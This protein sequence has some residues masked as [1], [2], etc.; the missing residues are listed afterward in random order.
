[1]K[2]TVVST[3]IN[4]LENLYGEEVINEAKRESNWDENMIITPLMNIE[5]EK[6]FDLINTMA[7]KV[8]KKE[9]ELWREIGKQNIYS[10]SEWFPSYFEGRQLKNFL[11]L[12]DT[13]HKQL[14]KMIP[15]ANPPR[16]IPREIDNR[17]IELT[18]SSQ[19]GMFDYFLGLLEGSSEFFEEDIDFKEKS[20]NTT[21]EKKSLKVV[22]TFSEKFKSTHNYRLS[23]FLSFGIFNKIK[24]KLAIAFIV[25]NL[26]TLYGFSF[27]HPLGLTLINGGFALLLTHFLTKPFNI[28]NKDLDRI[29]DLDLSDSINLKSNDEF[30]EVTRHMREIK[31]SIRKDILF[32][33]GGT[34]DMY[35]FTDEIVDISDDMGRVSDNISTVVEEVANGAQEQAE[36]TENSAYIVD[37]NINK[38]ENLVEAGNES[39]ENLQSAVKSIQQSAQEVE[40]VNQRIEKV[41]NAFANV[42]DL[43]RE[44]SNQITQIME[45]VDTVSDIAGQTNLLSLNASIEAARSSDNSQGFAVVAEE[46]RELAEDSKKAGQ[47]INDNLEEFTEKVQELVKGI[48]SQFANLE[49]SNKVLE[50]VSNSNKKSSQNIENATEQVVGIVEDLNQETQKIGEVIENLNSLAA[51]AEENSAS[52]QEMSAS[53]SDYSEKIKEMTD[54]IKQMEDLVGNFQNSLLKYNT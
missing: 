32:L 38:I 18:Y 39:K 42:N 24:Y 49:E 40:D 43:G 2:G 3:W 13:V 4:T 11:M 33:K 27:N 35:N 15:G 46:I 34:D 9:S 23:K 14:T 8:Q 21:G 52:S 30:E 17:T 50:E 26:I 12:M 6:A 10:F 48:S 7:K 37:N 22:I 25:I 45:I 5:D 29:K 20:R 16:I 47:T 53:V 28:L 36:E 44:L 54:Y 19:R 1:M 51:I 41:K 31:K